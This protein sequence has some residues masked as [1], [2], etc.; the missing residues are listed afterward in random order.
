MDNDAAH[1]ANIA[2]RM[3]LTGDYL[4]LIDHNGDYLDKP[5]FLFWT[6]ALSYHLFGVTSFAYKFPSFLFTLL[7][8]FSVYGLGKELYNKET[9]LLAALVTASSCCFVLANSDVRM[10]AILTA[11]VVFSVWQLVFFVN[12]KKTLSIVLA[13]LGLAVGFATK[14][15]VGLITPL[16]ALLFYILYKKAWSLFLNPKWLLLVFL[17]FVFIS[18]VLFC[19][20]QQFNL[21]PEKIIRGKSNINGVEYLL[22]KISA[23]RFQGK[24]GTESDPFFFFHSFLWSFSPWGVLAFLSFFKRFSV[25]INRKKEWLTIGVFLFLLIIISFSKYQLPHYLPLVAPWAALFTVDFFLSLKTK[26]VAVKT[27]FYLQLFVSLVLFV[28]TVLLLFWLFSE[29][30]LFL[31]VLF[32]LFFFLFFY[33]VFLNPHSFLQ[34]SFLVPVCVSIF[35]Y[36]Y[37]NTSFYPNLLRYQSGKQLVEQVRG[38]V[39]F[40]EVYFWKNVYSSSFSFYS[41]SLR[42]EYVSN[43]T[44]HNNPFWL[45]FDAKNKTAVDA[46]GFVF[47]RRFSINDY[48]ITRLKKDFIFPKSRTASLSPVFLYEVLEKK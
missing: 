48:E 35:L 42:K 27:V 6:S 15:H 5:H 29:K 30:N 31:L 47:G 25:F 23:E 18:P 44:K 38:T 26:P 10:D 41:A 9:G 40:N 1:H 17:F 16:V 2:L 24:F 37:L 33:F 14:S 21:H 46:A 43:E 36:F 7:G 34:K 4:N 28:L 13:S 8:L 11:C 20:Y 45:F 39:N 22:F 12:Y 19:Y 3:Y 32:L